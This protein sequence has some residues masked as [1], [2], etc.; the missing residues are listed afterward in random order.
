MAKRKPGYIPPDDGVK[1]IECGKMIFPN[2]KYYYAK[3]SKAGSLAFGANGYNFIHVECYK[4]LLKHTHTHT[5]NE[6]K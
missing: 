1:C 2:D 4:K 6:R 3:K 5:R